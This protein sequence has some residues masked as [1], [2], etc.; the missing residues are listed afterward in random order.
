MTTL[1]LFAFAVA[2]LT[3]A[4]ALSQAPIKPEA[5]ESPG[6]AALVQPRVPELRAAGVKQIV[7]RTGK[8]RRDIQALTNFGP[9]YLAWP[10]GVAEQVPFEIYLNSDGTNGVFATGFSDATRAK[11]SAALDAVVPQVIK[12]ANQARANSQRPKA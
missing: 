6:L 8:G 7:V 5:P 10:K 3:S 11:F 4:S 12:G 9:V 2:A 1:R